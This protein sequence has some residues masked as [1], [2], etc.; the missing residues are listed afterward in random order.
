MIRFTRSPRDM[1]VAITVLSGRHG[2]LHRRGAEGQRGRNGHYTLHG[3][4]VAICSVL[5]I[6]NRHAAISSCHRRLGSLNIS[7][8]ET[9]KA[10][11]K[12]G[13]DALVCGS[14]R[15][16]FLSPWCRRPT[17]RAMPCDDQPLVSKEACCA[18]VR[19]FA[20]SCAGV[21]ALGGRLRAI[22]ARC[23]QSR[24]GGPFRRHGRAM[25]ETSGMRTKRRYRNL[26]LNRPPLSASVSARR[27]Q[28]SRPSRSR[29]FLTRI[30]FRDFGSNTTRASSTSHFLPR[31]FVSP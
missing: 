17:G 23:S 15:F 31:A 27:Q 11:G 18:R 7:D 19:S 16:F 21:P 22:G 8:R 2:N 3:R 1:F 29:K 20:T 10:P 30:A 4:T 12:Y 14:C 24:S 13:A 6:L 5:L 25:V 26:A 9:L 28:G